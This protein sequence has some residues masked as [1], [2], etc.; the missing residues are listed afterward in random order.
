[1]YQHLI[2]DIYKLL[3]SECHRQGSGG[4]SESCQTAVSTT[5]IEHTSNVKIEFT[6]PTNSDGDRHITSSSG[7]LDITVSIIQRGYLS[8]NSVVVSVSKISF[9]YVKFMIQLCR[10]KYE[11]MGNQR[12]ELKRS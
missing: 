9:L 5:D 10:S 6:K 2:I 8:L 1:M 12:N 3:S 11:E 4:S 7:E